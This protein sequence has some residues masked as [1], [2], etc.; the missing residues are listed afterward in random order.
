MTN[1][2]HSNIKF[3]EKSKLSIDKKHQ[4]RKSGRNTSNSLLDELL[5]IREN[6]VK[7]LLWGYCHIGSCGKPNLKMVKYYSRKNPSPYNLINIEK[8]WW[9]ISL[10][11]RIFVAYNPSEI[12]V[13]SQNK[14][15]HTAASSFIKYN[16]Y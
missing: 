16:Y 10:A 11:A 15:T 8:M 13:V 9:K 2:K 6:D 3:H 7:W 4:T 5:A 1:P 12:L 14:L